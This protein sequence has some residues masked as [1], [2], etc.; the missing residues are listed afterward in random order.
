MVDGAAQEPPSEKRPALSELLW[1]YLPALRAHLIERKGICPE[2]ADDL[3]QEFVSKKFLEGNLPG[4]ANPARGKF[5][6]LLLTALDR[7]VIS[8]HRSAALQ[9]GGVSRAQSTDPAVLEALIG[10]GRPASIFDTTWARAVIDQT[11]QR[12]EAH[13]R[14]TKRP[15]IWGVFQYRVLHPTIEG[16]P[17]PGYEEL[18]GRFGFQSP[19]QASNVLMTAKRLF[20][21][22]LRK[23]VADYAGPASSVEEEIRDLWKILSG[24]RAGADSP[25]RIG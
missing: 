11:L 20:A 10:D 4:K 19:A 13:C 5:R 21:R 16:R 25:P 3:L 12:M 17:A 23:V 1:L 15:D 7:F 2:Q 18:V 14:S 8:T 22:L 9:T 24:P 6:T